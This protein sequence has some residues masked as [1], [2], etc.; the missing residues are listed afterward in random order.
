M[1]KEELEFVKL[2]NVKFTE[3][4]EDQLND[5]LDTI[6]LYSKRKTSPKFAPA[7]EAFVKSL[8]EKRAFV[9]VE[10]KNVDLPL[11]PAKK[12]LLINLS[13]LDSIPPSN[14]N[15]LYSIVFYAL[16]YYTAVLQNNLKFILAPHIGKLFF[17]SFVR[18][19]GRTHGLMSLD[20]WK[21]EFMQY[22]CTLYVYKKIC[23][24]TDVVKKYKT[25]IVRDNHFMFPQK[26]SGITLYEDKDLTSISQLLELFRR[27]N[28]ININKNIYVHRVFN[29]IKTSG[30]T[31]FDNFPRFSG[32]ILAV[33]FP[34]MI[35]SP[36]IKIF[37]R[38][39]YDQCKKLLTDKIQLIRD[40]NELP[41]YL[42]ENI[43]IGDI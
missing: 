42:T 27:L 23:G 31:M 28:I 24:I 15:L 19:L 34:N 7:I 25:A 12:K 30:L 37:N 10:F 8:Q 26:I 18:L 9:A 2:D 5:L 40:F 33:M 20:P 3:P 35:F 29:T 14:I 16:G 39:A 13:L 38:P 17:G 11:V 1:I 32:Q 43:Q 6:T 36:Y 22:A 41:K 21:L 4:T